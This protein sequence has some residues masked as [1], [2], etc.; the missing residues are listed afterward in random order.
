MKGGGARQQTQLSLPALAA[1]QGGPCGQREHRHRTRA[2]PARHPRPPGRKDSILLGPAG[3]ARATK[4]PLSRDS[5]ASTGLR[6]IQDSAKSPV[7]FQVFGVGGRGG[8]WGGGVAG[9]KGRQVQPARRRACT[10]LF[11]CVRARECVVCVCARAHA[12]V[13]AFVRACKRV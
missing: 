10:C 9:G 13:R 7:L 8:T 4:F 3:P 6:E 5:S 12:C 11:V 1:E 2:A